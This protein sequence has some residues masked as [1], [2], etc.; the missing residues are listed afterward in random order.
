MPVPK[1]KTGKTK[2]RMRRSHHALKG[3]NLSECAN[4]GSRI[5]PHRVCVNC[6]WYK[7]RYAINAED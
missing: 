3:R 4:C 2:K 7:E 5:V 6:G 1:R